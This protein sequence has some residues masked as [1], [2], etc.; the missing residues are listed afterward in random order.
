MDRIYPVTKASEEI[1]TVATVD[2][3]I[4]GTQRKHGAGFAYYLG[5]RPRDD[6]AGSLGKEARTWFEILSAAGAYPPSGKF[7]SIND[8]TEYLSRSTEYLTTRF[9]NGTVVVAS[10]YK[11]HRESWPGGFARNAE[12]D[13]RILQENPLPSD[14]INLRSFMVNGH[15]VDY[16]GRLI[17]AFNVD[18]QKRLVGFEGHDCDRISIDGKEFVLSSQKQTHITWAPVAQARRIKGKA[19]MQIFLNGSGEISI[20]LETKRTQLQLWAEEAVP[21][22]RGKLI[23]FKMENGMLIVNATSETNGRWLYLTGI[24][25]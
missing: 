4:V 13:E 8:N 22:S 20:P 21:G 2:K 25:E 23:P 15:K 6:Q 16:S 5:F 14:S 12:E 1:E 24:G 18:G 17:L 7:A 3:Q 19:F 9:P 10:H 11:S